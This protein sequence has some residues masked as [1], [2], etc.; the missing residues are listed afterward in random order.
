MGLVND[1]KEFEVIHN[2]R[3]LFLDDDGVEWFDYNIVFK[4]NNE[5]F[6]NTCINETKDW[7]V[8]QS[9][10][11]MQKIENYLEELESELTQIDGDSVNAII[12]EDNIN[13]NI[14]PLVNHISK[15]N[16]FHFRGVVKVTPIIKGMIAYLDQLIVGYNQERIMD[17]NQFISTLKALEL[18]NK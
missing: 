15:F 3:R 17:A 9:T 16:V 1:R 2:S 12:F 11:D 4:T 14:N 7:N 5:E 6:H 10:L 13:V 8:L 18:Y